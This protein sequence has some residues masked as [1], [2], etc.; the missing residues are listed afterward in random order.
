MAEG[1]VD[2]DSD[3][4]DHA[5]SQHRARDHVPPRAVPQSHAAD[6]AVSGIQNDRSWTKTG[7]VVSPIPSRKAGDLLLRM[8]GIICTSHTSALRVAIAHIYAAI[9]L[10]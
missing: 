4:F 5:H 9:A 10:V 3:A 8:A 2:G 6:T 1:L 7:L